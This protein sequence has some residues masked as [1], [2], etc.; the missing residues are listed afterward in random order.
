MSKINPGSNFYEDNDI[1]SARSG[2]LQETNIMEPKKDEAGKLHCPLCDRVFSTREDY[3]SHALSKHQISVATARSHLATFTYDRGFHFFTAIG[4]YTGKTAVSLETF[5][6]EVE[7][8]PIES[9]DFH[10]K[11]ADF[12]KWMRDIIKDA[13]LANAIG[14]IE[15]TLAGEPLRQRL[16]MITNDRIKELEM[17][18]Q[19]ASA[20]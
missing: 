20:P 18:I 12:Q 4:Q 1:Q 2:G 13:P 7:I 6:K 8:A 9:I 3:I 5:A 14:N 10:F 16:L 17:Q 19:P 11:R 15:K